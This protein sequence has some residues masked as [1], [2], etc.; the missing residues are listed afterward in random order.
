MTGPATSRSPAQIRHNSHVATTDLT[1]TEAATLLQPPIPPARLRQI[2]TALQWQPTGH[3][4][5]G[6]PGHPHPTYPAHRIMDLH[7]ALLPYIGVGQL[8]CA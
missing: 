1:I 3:R 5:T 8:L 6:H 4:R 7:A 2:I